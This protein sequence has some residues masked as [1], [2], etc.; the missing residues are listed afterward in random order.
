MFGIRHGPKRYLGP[1]NIVL[2][3]MQVLGPQSQK[4]L[5]LYLKSPQSWTIFRT[6]KTVNSRSGPCLIMFEQRSEPC[7]GHSSSLLLAAVEALQVAATSLT[8]SRAGLAF[9]FVRSSDQFHDGGCFCT[10]NSQSSQ[11]RVS[12]IQ[13]Q[14]LMQPVDDIC[15]ESIAQ[16]SH[17]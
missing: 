3:I 17:C 11:G 10:C 9:A 1:S 13:R 4:I 12:Y 2:N 8:R 15:V 14:G 16:G 7:L 6:S 5:F